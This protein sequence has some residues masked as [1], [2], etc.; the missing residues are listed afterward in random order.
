MYQGQNSNGTLTI[1]GVDERLSEGPIT[2]VPDVGRR[3]GDPHSGVTVSQLK[4]G[5]H[6]I[7][8]NQ[9][10]WLDTGTNVLLLG[11]ALLDAVRTSMCA[12]ASLAHCASLWQNDCMELTAEEIAAYP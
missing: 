12:D 11:P 1:G 10:G 9:T 7:S 2:Y 5:G 8:V 4:V 6:S 3:T